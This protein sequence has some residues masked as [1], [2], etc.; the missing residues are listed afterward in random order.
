MRIAAYAVVAGIALIVLHAVTVYKTETTEA[1]S[2]Y[3]MGRQAKADGL[4][5][6]PPE[7]DKLHLKRAWMFGWINQENP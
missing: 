2:A 3:N 4:P 7:F 6:D 5:G 1:Q